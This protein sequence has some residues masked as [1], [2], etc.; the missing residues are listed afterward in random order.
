MRHLCDQDLEDTKENSADTLGKR[1]DP[2]SNLKFL[3]EKLVRCY[4]LQL[5]VNLKGFTD[6]RFSKVSSLFQRELRKYYDPVLHWTSQLRTRAGLPEFLENTHHASFTMSGPVITGK[7]TEL[8]TKRG[9][10]GLAQG[11][12]RRIYHFDVGV[13]AGGLDD[14]FEWSTSQLRMVR[15]WYSHRRFLLL[16][17]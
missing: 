5:G 8:L 16:T 9:W 4:R 15:V 2:N 7:V 3:G 17:L 14:K 13:S 1:L 12:T 10:K 6:R 11:S